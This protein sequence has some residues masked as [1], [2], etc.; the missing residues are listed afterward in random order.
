[1]WALF[2]ILVRYEIT[3]QMAYPVR[4][5]DRLF[6]YAYPVFLL[7]ILIVV[8]V[9]ALAI[10][11]YKSGYDLIHSLHKPLEMLLQQMLLDIIFIAALTE[12]SITILGYLK[13]GAVHVRYIIDTILIIM[14]NEVVSI[15]FKHPKLEEAI[16]ISIII[17]VLA[18]VRL[19]V[20]RYEPKNTQ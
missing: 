12:L 11:V 14:L 8:I 19:S 13:D 6:F 20:V 1:M 2:C 5:G 10:G 7:N 3:H 15:W 9:V 16:S 17:L 4:A 18:A